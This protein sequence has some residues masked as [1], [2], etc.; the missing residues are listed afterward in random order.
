MGLFHRR[1]RAIADEI[2]C[3]GLRT[4]ANTKVSLKNRRWGTTDPGR[5]QFLASSWLSPG[6]YI[7][8]KN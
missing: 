6:T 4:N 3:I 7:T 8:L 5:T 2:A 1:S